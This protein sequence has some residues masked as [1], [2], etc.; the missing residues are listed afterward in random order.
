MLA[1]PR[2]ARVAL[3]PHEI[4]M[5]GGAYLGFGDGGGPVQSPQDTD[6]FHAPLAPRA[7][8]WAAQYTAD[9]AV[10]RIHAA[11]TARQFVSQGMTI[12]DGVGLAVLRSAGTPEHAAAGIVYGDTSGHRHQDLLDVQLWVKGQPFLSDLGYPQSWASRVRWEGHWATHNTVWATIPGV[13]SNLAGRGRV[14]RSIEMEGLQLIE[15]EAARWI[16]GQDDQNPSHWTQ[17]DVRFRR[18]LALLQ[19]DE[20]GVVLV[21][22]SRVQG[23]DEHFRLCRGLEG[24][25]E[26]LDA[27]T[28][29]RTGTLAGP[30]VERGDH[31]SL[32]HTDHRGLA[33]MDEV[34]AV[35]QTDGW[36][37]RWHSRRN[38]DAEMDMHVLRASGTQ[39]LTGRATATMGT[40]ESSTYSYRTVCWRIP[41]R[42]QEASNFDLVFEPRLGPTNLTSVRRIDAQHESAI[43]VDIRTR[44]GRHLQLRWSPEGDTSFAGEP[45]GALRI[46]L[47]DKTIVTGAPCKATITAL[48]REV[49]WIEVDGLVG[50]GVG[51]RLIINPDGRGHNYRVVDCQVVDGGQRLGLDVTSILGRSRVEKLEGAQLLG[52][53]TVF[54]R[55]GYLQGA[56]LCADLLGDTQGIEILQAWNPDAHHTQFELRTAPTLGVTEWG[57][58]VDY[59]VGDTVAWEPIQVG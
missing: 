6:A 42:T 45:S 13:S 26:I 35:A 19:T 30:D 1:D 12:L 18:L 14:L 4:S 2:A 46:D 24:E 49:G 22:L 58:V 54:T 47:D 50:I 44:R 15:I 27:T 52:R 7:L 25:L 43:G 37:G 5:T 8:A 51:D 28:T 9:E 23:G 3:A 20:D 17:T 36:C 10:A 56:R 21:D 41:E 16:Q 31:E 29:P 48:D 59:V 34:E 53:Y 33:W 55:T 39:A 32:P 38:D 57:W 40:P 11:V